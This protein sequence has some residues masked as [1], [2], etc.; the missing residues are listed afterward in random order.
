MYPIPTYS[1]EKN[2]CKYHRVTAVT[3]GV[4]SNYLPSK[5]QLPH[6]PRC[7]RLSSTPHL[8]EPNRFGK[9]WRVDWAMVHDMLVPKKL[10]G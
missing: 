10:V 7:Q 6:Q 2:V 8:H 5:I 3:V 4:Q 1:Y 9:D